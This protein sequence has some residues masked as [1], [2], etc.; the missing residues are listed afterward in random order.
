M[1]KLLVVV[2][3]SLSDT[4][5]V[6]P[7]TIPK[8]HLP[9]CARSFFGVVAMGDASAKAAAANGGITRVNSVEHSAT[10]YFFLGDFCT[11]VRGS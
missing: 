3:D 9:A 8:N 7:A 11:I 4:N 6:P 2:T 1:K 5:H 10:H